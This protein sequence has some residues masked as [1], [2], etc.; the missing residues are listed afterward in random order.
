MLYK[1]TNRD[2]LPI[3]RE[4]RKNMTKEERHLWYDFLRYYPVK[5]K[6][7]YIIGNYI[8]DFYCASARLVIEVDGSQHY[9]DKGE[10]RDRI[11]TGFIE[12]FG[13][14]V[15]RIPNNEVNKNFTGVCE[16]LDMIIKE[17]RV[18]LPL[19]QLTLPALLTQESH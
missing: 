17:R 14:M 2:L 7:Q 15:V 10:M 8:A 1:K 11:R 9:E 16:Y 13:L 3:A 19:S 12:E 5:I 18:Y 6:K 4:L